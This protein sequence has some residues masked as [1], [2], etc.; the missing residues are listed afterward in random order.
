MARARFSTL[1][2]PRNCFARPVSSARVLLASYTLARALVDDV[3]P[4]KVDE[5]RGA[6]VR[7]KELRGSVLAEVS[8]R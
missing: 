2:S 6:A 8:V 7:E 4:Q 5:V 3:L 1:R